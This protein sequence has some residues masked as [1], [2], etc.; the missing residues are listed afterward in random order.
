MRQN[1]PN[2]CYLRLSTVSLQKLPFGTMVVVT[3]VVVVNDIVF[4]VVTVVEA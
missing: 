4:C 3:T 1:V 2:Y